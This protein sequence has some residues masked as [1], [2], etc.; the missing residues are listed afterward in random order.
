MSSTIRRFV[1]RLLTSII[2]GTLFWGI[3]LFCPARLLTFLLAAALLEILIFEWP[4]I[5]PLRNLSCWLA[6]P[7]YPVLPFLAMVQMNEQLIYR[8]IFFFA[9][10]LA[11]AFD[12]GSYLVGKTFGR[13]SL[14]V[15]SPDK[16]WEGFFGGVL[17]V[18]FILPFF[19]G[20][21]VLALMFLTPA[22]SIVALAGDLFESWFKRR[23]GV[24]DA[25]F[26]LPGHGG[27]LDRFDSIIAVV[28]F[29]Y[30]L[31]DYLVPLLATT[32]IF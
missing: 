26:V 13:H 6:A 2:L 24:K 3:Y 4:V 9:F 23:V 15:L 22:I 10:V 21:N 1:E 19:I 29:C 17:A 20:L 11:P 5:C 31:K 27:L 16:T 30:L 7:F 14:S 18:L 12:T 8:P 32:S 25:G 28:L